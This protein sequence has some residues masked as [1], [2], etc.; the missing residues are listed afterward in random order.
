MFFY[1]YFR[2]RYAWSWFRT[3]AICTACLGTGFTRLECIEIYDHVWLT[4]EQ[5]PVCI[6]SMFQ[7][8][9]KFAL[10]QRHATTFYSLFPLFPFFQVLVQAVELVTFCLKN[11]FILT[12]KV[13]LFGWIVL[14][15]VSLWNVQQIFW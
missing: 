14:R 2:F 13:V 8:I 3:T 6:D 4:G 1:L 10:Y 11:K 12:S 7:F 9:W 5:R 15:I